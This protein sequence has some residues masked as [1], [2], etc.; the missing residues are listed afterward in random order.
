MT[1]DG[2]VH[3]Q[4]NRTRVQV[5]LQCP[6]FSLILSLSK[7]VTD[8]HRGFTIRYASSTSSGRATS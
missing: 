8:S 4:S 3:Y 7:D 2:Q 5:D 1:V 6:G